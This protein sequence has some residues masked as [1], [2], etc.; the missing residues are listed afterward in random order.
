MSNKKKSKK[1][2]VECSDDEDVGDI[3]IGIFCSGFDSVTMCMPCGDFLEYDSDKCCD[4]IDAGIFCMPCGLPKSFKK[5]SVLCKY[6][7]C[8]K[9]S[10]FNF[11]DEKGAKFCAA[12]KEKG[13]VDIKSKRCKETGCRKGPAFNIEGQ[14]PEY[15]SEHKDENMVNVKNKKCAFKGCKIEPSYGELG[16]KPIYCVTHKDKTMVHIKGKKCDN[17]GCNKQPVFN[18]S[19]E[20][21]GKFCKEHKEES[22]IDIKNNQCIH[23]GCTKHPTFNLETEQTAAYCFEHKKEG[24]VDVK[25]GK[26]TNNGCKNRPY[27]NTSLGMSPILCYKHKKKGMINVASTKCQFEGC[28]TFPVFNFPDVVGGIFCATHKDDGMID[29]AN[30]LCKTHMCTTH[31]YN[32]KYK[33]YCLNCF[34]HLFPNEPAYKNFKTKEQNVVSFVKEEFANLNWVEDKVIQNGISLKR[35]DIFLDCEEYSIIVE[36]DENQHR[37][38]QEICENKRVMELSQDLKFKTCVFIRFNPDGYKDKDNK[39]VKSC[40]KANKWG[41][42]TISENKKEWDK[43]LD[44]LKVEINY[45]LKMKPKKM[46]EIVKLFYDEI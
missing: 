1:A 40:W 41:V 19:G 4:D 34:I 9:Y 7:G 11:E 38:Y 29:V 16:G 5:N 23:E 43:R 36:I 39:H 33:G 31:A 14:K 6:E 26:C 15:C 17:N 27:Y 2:L 8:A 20:Q 12:H 37:G 45:W 3:D 28:L 10:S 22:M 25:H 32:E 24:M 44:K 18:F 46:I 21:F 13:M 42:L 35:P 30:T